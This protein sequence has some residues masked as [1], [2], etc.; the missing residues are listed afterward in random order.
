MK[1]KICIILLAILAISC[2]TDQD[3]EVRLRLANVSDLDYTNIT[4]R[5]G[6]PYENLEAGAISEYQ[7]FE[8]SYSYM[9]VQLVI[10]QDTLVIQPIDFVGESFVPSGDY[11]YE[12]NAN[13]ENN[14]FGS[15]NAVLVRD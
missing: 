5:N 9:Y 2:T 14:D 1:Y 15:L 7:V 4:I 6:V 12:I 3:S 11:T 8:S 10:D 13:F